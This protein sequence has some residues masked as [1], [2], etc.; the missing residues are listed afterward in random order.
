MLSPWMDS[1][2]LP[3]L[4]KDR[5]MML[6][7]VSWILP[8][9]SKMKMRQKCTLGS[10]GKWKGSRKSRNSWNFFWWD[11]HME[12]KMT[13]RKSKEVLFIIFRIL[14]VTWL[15]KDEIVLIDYASG[16]SGHHS[17]WCPLLFFPCLHPTHVL[18]LFLSFPSSALKSQPHLQG[19][20]LTWWREIMDAL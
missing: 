4:Y 3:L 1:R 10:G 12:R 18:A 17:L 20:N 8:N 9:I 6:F 19:S 7:M 13:Q 11:F 2:D 15:S 14:C 16:G 5:D